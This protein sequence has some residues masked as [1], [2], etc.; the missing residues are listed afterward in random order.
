[1]NDSGGA[2]ATG[3]PGS[4]S[5]VGIRTVSNLSGEKE[6][7][8]RSH[9]K[10]KDYENRTPTCQLVAEGKEPRAGYGVKSRKKGLAL[11]LN[12]ET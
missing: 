11:T 3:L 10:E 5:R 8:C 9:W 12:S 1:M 2:W 4:D 7:I 6:Q